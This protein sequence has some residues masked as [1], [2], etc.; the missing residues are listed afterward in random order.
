MRQRF[1]RSVRHGV[2]AANTFVVILALTLGSGGVLAGD[3]LP[4]V[5]PL[6]PAAPGTTFLFGEGRRPPPEGESVPANPYSMAAAG[7]V[8]GDGYDDFLCSAAPEALGLYVILLIHGR[9]SPSPEVLLE[10]LSDDVTVIRAETLNEDGLVEESH[11]IRPGLAPAGDIDGDGFDDVLVSIPYDRRAYLLF[12]SPEFHGTEVVLGETFLPPPGGALRWRTSGSPLGGGPPTNRGVAAVGDLNGDGMPELAFGAPFEDDYEGRVYV[13]SWSPE[14]RAE[15]EMDVE[16]IGVSLPGFVFHGVSVNDGFPTPN[17][18]DEAGCVVAG[19]GDLNGDGLDDICVGYARDFIDVVFGSP[20]LPPRLM[21]DDIGEHGV[22][23]R[24]PQ[25]VAFT[26]DVVGAGDLDGD[27]YDDLTLS[28]VVPRTTMSPGE[29]GRVYVVWG[30]PDFP[31]ALGLREES[32]VLILESADNENCDVG[33][34]H[35]TCWGG[36]RPGAVLASPGDID[37]DGY[38]DL[39]FGAHLASRL[40]RVRSGMAYLV[41]GGPGL[42]DDPQHQLLPE[43]S[44]DLRTSVMVGPLVGDE[45][46][47]PLA[48]V[49]DFDGDGKPDLA[50]GARRWTYRGLREPPERPRIFLILTGGEGGVHFLRGDSNDNGAMDLSDAVFTLNFLFSGGPAPNC[51]DSADIDDSGTLDLTDPVRFLNFS[52]LGGPAPE[53]P[54]GLCGIDPMADELSCDSFS[55]CEVR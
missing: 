38:P 21:L 29:N 8:D 30:R 46:G 44:G 3:G 10:G 16:E 19:A 39:F 23:I 22:R 2:C 27:G 47:D 41:Y 31:P 6:P 33:T 45:L 1:I 34:H 50:V 49:G 14:L 15:E 53:N 36:D 43:I 11:L 18:G 4:T 51:L 40:D 37:F 32:G 24:D 48:G 7:D 5:A 42:R 54:F 35:G 9:P 26:M 25:S 55:A 20:D 17:G 52:F 12:G 28:T 13:T